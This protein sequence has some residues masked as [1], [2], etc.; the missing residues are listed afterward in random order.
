MRRQ[1]FGKKIFSSILAASMMISPF[2]GLEIVHAANDL[3]GDTAAEAV[4]FSVGVEER[5]AIEDKS[6]VDWYKFTTDSTD[7]FYAIKLTNAA[8][9]DEV[10]FRVYE[11]ADGTK[12]VGSSSYGVD[13]KTTQTSDMGKLLS[14][15][16][17][18]VW[19]DA[20]N[21]GTGEYTFQVTKTEDDVKDTVAEAQEIAVNTEIER[22]LQNIDDDDY[23]KFTTDGSDSFYSFSFT[24]ISMSG[25]AY[26][27]VYYDENCTEYVAKHNNGVNAKAT[28]TNNMVKL[29]KNHTYYIKVFSNK[30][31][32]YKFSVTS[33]LD[34]VNDTAT[35]ANSIALNDTRYY[36]IQN[37]K[38]VDYFTFQT[39]D[40]TE[41][42]LIFANIDLNGKVNIEIYSGKDCLNNQ[43]VYSTSLSLK[44]SVDKTKGKIKLGRFKNYY[45]K[46]TG[47]VTGKYKLG[48]DAAAP[49]NLKT[50]KAGSKK[51]TVKWGKVTRANGYEI[52]RSQTRNGKY[53]K[54]KTIKKAN[55]VKFVD[56]K[57]LKKGKTYFYKVRAYKKA[58]GK[59][60]YS[61]FSTVKSIKV[62]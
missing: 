16:T 42:R 14:N 47:S 58:K 37:V 19:V 48:I 56:K 41:Y 43:K 33:I 49:D 40:F 3:E 4:E 8:V 57:G 60:Y 30:V 34:D 46:V 5:H 26:Y 11:D 20:D 17:Y 6:D 15:H 62:K 1:T 38:D 22:G 9:T 12:K 45:V 18:Y 28:Q 54:I 36:N 32:S 7:S 10:M 29:E 55:T 23:F 52:Y 13:K 44:G 61:A 59:T 35:E 53:K 24:N 27:H 50:S 25:D 39:S 31:G 21:S 2:G 51:V